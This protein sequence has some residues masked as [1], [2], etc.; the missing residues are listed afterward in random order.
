[1]A[2]SFE[3]EPIL[4]RQLHLSSHVK[5]RPE[6]VKAVGNTTTDRRAR[7]LMLQGH[8]RMAWADASLF[9]AS[10]C[11]SSFYPK[12]GQPVVPLT[13]KE[14]VMVA[15]RKIR[16]IVCSAVRVPEQHQ[17]SAG[18]R[19]TCSNSQPSRINNPRPSDLLPWA[20]PYI[21]QLVRNLQREVRRERS[22]HSERSYLRQQPFLPTSPVAEMQPPS[23]HT[24][25]DWQHPQERRSDFQ[26]N[27]PKGGN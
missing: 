23:P 2:I 12:L 1:M 15:P 17:Q 20:D 21:S 27:P 18:N 25:L 6:V 10:F 5:R 22:V 16:K 14:F 13:E 4:A 3:H 19:Q 11:H 9:S 7:V 24:V 8:T 26:N